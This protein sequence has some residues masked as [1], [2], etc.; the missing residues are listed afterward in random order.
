MARQKFKKPKSSKVGTIIFYSIFSLAVI[1]AGIAIWLGLDSLYKTL[2]VYERSREVYKAEEV[3]EEYFSPCRFDVLYDMQEIELSEFENKNDFVKY[4]E[5]Q[6]KDKEIIYREVSMG[7]GDDKKYTVAADKVKF[8]DFILTKNPDA[9]TPEETWMLDSVSTFYQKNES[10]SVR[11]YT[12][13]KLYVN[14]IET[15]DSYITTDN[16]TTES[17]KRVPDGVSGIMLR[18]Y[19]IDGLLLAPK[20]KV[21]N[22]FGEES[23]LVYDEKEK[24]YVEQIVY[25][26]IPDE[27]KTRVI[28][29]TQTYAKYVTLDASIYNVSQFFDT[30]AKPYQNLL[31]TETRWYTPHVSYEF[32]DVELSEYYVYDENTFSIRYKSNHYVLRTWNAADRF[33]FPI[34][35]TLYLK[36]INGQ[37]YVYELISN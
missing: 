3:L 23:T 36:N 8:A 21:V 24:I 18:E 10:V 25:D 37:F 30:T 34:D 33:N 29:A 28:N 7:L 9:Q 17:C 16:I 31:I 35:F 6:Y 22:R 4:M 11:L 2:D 14:G 15:N 32:S 1:G 26:D 19:K 27:I 13:S 5:N 20:L 12:T